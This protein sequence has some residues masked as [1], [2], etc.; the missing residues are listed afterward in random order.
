MELLKESVVYSF[1]KD[2]K[3]INKLTVDE[4]KSLNA[5]PNSIALSMIEDLMDTA[6]KYRSASNLLSYFEIGMLKLLSR[7]KEPAQTVSVKDVSKEEVKP[8]ETVKKVVVNKVEEIEKP[9]QVVESIKEVEPEPVIPVQ[10]PT[11][12]LQF[13]SVEIED[14]KPKPKKKK[15]LSKV[16]SH[17][18]NTILSL[19]NS[20]DKQKRLE[21][22]AKWNTIQ[23]YL[24]DLKYG[25]VAQILV[26][27]I[28]IALNEGFV[29]LSHTDKLYVNELNSEDN[30][31]LIEDFTQFLFGIEMRAFA[32]DAQ[33]VNELMVEFKR[34][35]AE[36]NLPEPMVFEKKKKK[37]VKPTESIEKGLFELF[38]EENVEI[39]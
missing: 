1:T 34:L 3:L 18:Q 31:E 16:E 2:E 5:I 36:N 14:L 10:E 15:V 7:V 28:P 12:D 20:G 25:R 33:S 24:T 32:V 9:V 6:E 13:E 21:I 27:A 22:N 17:D 19:L 37:V 11:E 38:G 35:H 39:I 4:A 8:V 30:Q 29:V 26:N 23:S